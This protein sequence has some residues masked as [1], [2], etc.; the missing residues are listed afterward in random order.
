MLKKEKMRDN[1]YNRVKT[2]LQTKYN[3][4]SQFLLHESVENQETRE[5]ILTGV[6]LQ[7]VGKVRG[8]AWRIANP[9]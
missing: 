1:L 5:Q 3:I 9:I 2:I 8:N 6:I 7:I 4:V